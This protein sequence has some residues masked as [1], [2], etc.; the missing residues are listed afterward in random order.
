MLHN[1]I[2]FEADKW[3]NNKK[4]VILESPVVKYHF[5]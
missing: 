1:A 5:N 4:Q 2:I 3:W